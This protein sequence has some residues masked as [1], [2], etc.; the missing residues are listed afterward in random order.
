MHI[1]P[2]GGKGGKFSYISKGDMTITCHSI[3]QPAL[4]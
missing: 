3:F 2:N 1:L 4:D